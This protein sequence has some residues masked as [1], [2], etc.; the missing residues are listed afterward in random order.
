MVVSVLEIVNFRNL[1]KAVLQC[2]PKLNLIVGGNASGKTSLLEALYFL[3]RA[4]SFRTRR[5]GELIHHDE[6]AFQIV[7]TV[8]N[9]KDGRFFPVGVRRSTQELSVRVDGMP[10]RSLADLAAQVPVLLLNPGSHRLLEGGPQQRRR[11]MDWGLFHTTDAFVGFWRRYNSVLRNRDAALRTGYSDRAMDAWDQE[12]VFASMALDGHRK[13]FCEALEDSLKP[14]LEQTLG[15]GCPCINYRRGWPQG[16][17]QDLLQLLRDGRDQDRRYGYTRLGAHRADF[18]IKLAGRP[19]PEYLS[20]GQQK[21]L[22]IALILAQAKLF[23][24]QRGKPCTLLIDDLPAELDVVHRLRVM[25]CL[26]TLD[27]Q[28]FIT[29]IEADMLNTALWE[30][31]CRFEICGGEISEMI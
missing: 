20:R 23:Q 21:L 26:A 2:S 5:V 11:F 9:R 16:E 13:T 1:R 19:A 25:E 8:S 12:L 24:K 7:A 14:F 30:E 22:V 10:A 15:T 17:D 4:R 31:S 3:G 6:T 29:A 18:Q 28:L 27:S